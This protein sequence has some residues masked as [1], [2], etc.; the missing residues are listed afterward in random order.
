MSVPVALKSG[1]GLPISAVAG[2]Y[3]MT[4]ACAKREPFVV[5]QERE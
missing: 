5:L 2:G 4:P 1:A 3:W